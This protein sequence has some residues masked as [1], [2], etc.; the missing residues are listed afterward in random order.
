VFA[1]RVWFGG[2]GSVLYWEILEGGSGNGRGPSFREGEGKVKSHRERG[3]KWGGGKG[4]PGLVMR[5][6]LVEVAKR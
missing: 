5:Q 2:W 4:L 6:D 1:F 3:S